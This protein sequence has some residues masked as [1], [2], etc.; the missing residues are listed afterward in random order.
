[1]KEV[2]GFMLLLLLVLLE[3]VAA[4]HH[5]IEHHHGYLSTRDIELVE[6]DSI[7]RYDTNKDIE[8]DYDTLIASNRIEHGHH[9]AARGAPIDSL[10]EDDAREVS[11][12]F[13]FD[14]DLLFASHRV[15]HDYR[16]TRNIDLIFKIEDDDTVNV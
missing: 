3:F 13:D 5:M 15:E 16:A 12:D 1:M 14:K 4:S 9:L 2:I 6:D 7:E 10:F 8:Y 11:E